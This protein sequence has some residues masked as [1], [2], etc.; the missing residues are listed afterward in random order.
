MTSDKARI[1]VAQRE[2]NLLLGESRVSLKKLKPMEF[3]VFLGGVLR[4]VDLRELRGFKPLEEHLTRRGDDSAIIPA[5]T[6]IVGRKKP[7]GYSFDL[8]THVSQVSRGTLSQVSHYRSCESGEETTDWRRANSWKNG[9]RIFR[10][11]ESI[12][13]LRRPSDHSRADENL[14]VVRTVFEKG[15]FESQMKVATIKVIPVPVTRFRRQFGRIYSSVALDLI[16]E[17]RTLVSRTL[18][19]LSNKVEAFRPTVVKLEQLGRSLGE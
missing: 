19:A 17:L 9:A 6:R 3:D 10:V 18:D 4:G 12:L 2:I 13:V 16:W 14:F 11:E 7:K 15:R 1:S 8:K 5:R